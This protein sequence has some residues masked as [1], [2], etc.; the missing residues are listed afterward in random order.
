V[1]GTFLALVGDT[2]L[3]GGGNPATA[4]A[5]SGL[6]NAATGLLADAIAP[7]KIGGV[8]LLSTDAVP[9][10][11]IE[12]DGLHVPLYSVADANALPSSARGMFLVL[13][14]GD[15]R[16][17]SSNS[18]ARVFEAATPGAMSDLKTGKRISIALAYD[19]QITGGAAGRGVNY[20]KLDGFEGNIRAGNLLDGKFNTYSMNPGTKSNQDVQRQVAALSQNPE[21]R[22]MYE[23]P[24]AAKARSTFNKLARMGV[25]SISV[26]VRR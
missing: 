22:L 9:L 5:I 11:H 1:F 21:F 20:L 23:M 17:R 12:I 14:G 8:Q 3:A 13:E 4:T 19:N 2:Q 18:P 15:Q 24:T 6:T 25:S 7:A 10:T 16:I 26:R